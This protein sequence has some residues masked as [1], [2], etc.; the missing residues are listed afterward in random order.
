[1]LLIDKQSNVPI[2]EQIIKQFETLIVRH[3]LKPDEM[4]PSVRKLSVDLSINPNTLQKA[5]TELEARGI[6]Y[7][8]AGKGR[9]VANNA[10]EIIKKDKDKSIRKLQESITKLA[11]MD[12]SLEEILGIVR[13]T[14]EKVMQN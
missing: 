10:R 4:L 3:V 8:E 7:S 11:Q 9:F 13:S 2:Y 6:C 12:V 1:L 14:F 5:Y